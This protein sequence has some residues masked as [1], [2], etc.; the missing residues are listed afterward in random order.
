MGRILPLGCTARSGGV[1]PTE[2]Y[3]R[4]LR[5][6]PSSGPRAEIFIRILD[7]E[8]RFSAIASYARRPL[9]GGVA[10]NRVRF[11]KRVLRGQRLR[12]EW[13][14]WAWAAGWARF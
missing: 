2:T 10:T 13:F 8:W 11:A 3:V 14:Q 6:A 7:R 9:R 4:T 12:F 5:D 1:H